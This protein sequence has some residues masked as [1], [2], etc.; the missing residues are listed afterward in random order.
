[1]ISV[2]L[3]TTPKSIAPLD[4]SVDLWY[5]KCKENSENQTKSLHMEEKR[6]V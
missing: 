6:N 2:C 4:I 1:M 3:L 5:N